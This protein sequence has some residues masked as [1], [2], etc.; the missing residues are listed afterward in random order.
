MKIVK[1][2]SCDRVGSADRTLKLD[3]GTTTTCSTKSAR[4][5]V[6]DITGWLAARVRALF[7]GSGAAPGS[8][9]GRPFF[10]RTLE[11]ATNLIVFVTVWGV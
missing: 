6:A 2:A 5:V 7:G 9:T 4:T 1:A 8:P 11:P 3:R 10:V